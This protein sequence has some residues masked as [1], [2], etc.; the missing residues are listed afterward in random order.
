MNDW[1]SLK[2]KIECGEDLD[3]YYEQLI[4][5]I[6]NNI[7]VTEV[8]P[9]G[10]LFYRARVFNVNDSN[11][12]CFSEDTYEGFNEENSLAPKAKD[13]KKSG[14]INRINESIL[15]LAEDKYTAMAEGR[16]GKQQSV[17][18]A[19]VELLEDVKI[20]E[21]KYKDSC[22]IENIIEQIY[23]FIALEFYLSVYDDKYYLITQYIAR[24]L[25]EIGFGGVKYSSSVSEN[26]MN[27]AI[28][29]T[30]NAKANNSKLYLTKSVLYYAERMKDETGSGKLIPKSIK[31]RFTQDEI[32]YFFNR[33][34]F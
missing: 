19:E 6:I 14:R 32:D 29:D 11:Y 3:E 16:S 7:G 17:S 34:R 31:D 33:M 4:P 12:E 2:Y 13:V 23:H 1:F 10:K 20:Y 15:Y 8:L 27:I 24:K 21:L 9:E 5:Y 30:K 26:G 22:Q 28:F 25:K 18:I